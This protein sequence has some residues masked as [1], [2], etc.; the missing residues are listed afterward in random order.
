VLLVSAD[1]PWLASATAFL[2][3]ATRT[4]STAETAAEA[5]EAA[6]GHPPD[7]AVIAPPIGEGSPL[8]L[9]SQLAVLRDQGRLGIVYVAEREREIADHGRLMK[10]GANDWFPRGLPASEAAKRI[11]ALVHEIRTPENARYLTRGPLCLDAAARQALVAGV[12][13][14][15]TDREFTILSVLVRAAGRMLTP[16]EVA[17]EIGVRRGSTVARSMGLQIELLREKLGAARGLLESNRRYGYRLRFV[18]P[19]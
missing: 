7:V 5:I 11:A 4:L 2:V 18:A 13:A 3:A 16:A 12:P 9:V 8:A 19:L 15:L 14:G 1:R 10:A 6:M 17:S